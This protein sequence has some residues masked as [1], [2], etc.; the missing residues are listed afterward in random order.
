MRAS[1]GWGGLRLRAV[2]S[3]FDWRLPY[4]SRRQPVL[5]SCAV[6][7]SQPLAAQAGLEMLRR[8][9][10]AAD[11]AVATAAALTVLE[12]TTNGIGGDAF[13][14]V[15]DGKSVHGLNGSGR[16]PAGLRREHILGATYPTRG[17]LPVTVPGQVDAWAKLH[18]RFGRLTFA[19]LFEPAIAAA[20]DGYLLPPNTAELWAR[21]APSLSM[22]HSHAVDWAAAFLPA[23]SAPTAGQRIVLNDHA[24]TMEAIAAS[25]GRDFYEGA[26]AGRILAHSVSTG[27]LLVRDDLAQHTSDW[28]E[29]IS[30]SYRDYRLHEIPPNGQGIAA[31]IAIGILRQFPLGE[32]DPDCPDAAHLG[33][34]AIKLGFAQAH[35]HVA[36]PTHMER[37]TAELLDDAH[38]TRL[39]KRIDPNRAQL[40]DA[41]IPKPGG[42]VY[43]CAADC[44][45]MM[46]SFIQ[47]N[48]TGWGS[49]IV[50]PGTGI[51]LQNRGACF[52]LA[53]GHPNEA[54]PLKRPYHTIIP[55][56]LTRDSAD[57]A[58][59]AAM[60]FGVM[61]GF[62]QPQ[63][64]VQVTSR[65]VDHHQNPQA[66]IDAPRWQ[67]LR[68]VQ[69]QVE[70][71]GASPRV[72][73]SDP[74]CDR[75]ESL[76]AA[77]RALGHDASLA[78][79]RSVTF[80]RGQAIWRLDGG[81]CAG[82]DSRAD[83]QAV[84]L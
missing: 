3:P 84:A 25:G 4:D 22:G 75:S 35:A 56:M 38:L 8:G 6:A 57:G 39:A 69:V 7:T 10:S 73:G 30:V 42:T 54:G 59:E 43:L 70:P 34:E 29:P 37:T 18:Q 71:A 21:A 50:V 67:W 12:P 41:G 33:I 15:W 36:D 83:G 64:H 65:V 14:L 19:E 13:A 61:G 77:L 16:S 49:G 23:G 9:G 40:F 11:A 31:L 74:A 48:Y 44:D 55:A 17:W 45:G 32:L 68:G 24:S 78:D 63:G 1:H 76:V 5:G 28:V 20:R 81:Y 2:S 66:A 46:V 51:A 80:G 58:M 47:S 52:S 82:S 62:M 26:L 79:S 60:A 27:G 53:A 72:R